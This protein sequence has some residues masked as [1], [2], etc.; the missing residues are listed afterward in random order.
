MV[1]VLHESS[2]IV[3]FFIE[4]DALEIKHN[5]KI[6]SAA[7]LLTNDMVHN[8]ID[9]KSSII[10]ES[11]RKDILEIEVHGEEELAFVHDQAYLSHI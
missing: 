8:E 1:V 3:T 10:V 6:V 5:G 7:F 2:Q 9:R 11:M 4:Q